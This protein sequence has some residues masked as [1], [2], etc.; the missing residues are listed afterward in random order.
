MKI[1]GNLEG[2]K[3]LIDGFISKVETDT[4]LTGLE[5][6]ANELDS[7]IVQLKVMKSKVEDIGDDL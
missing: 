5:E 7:V 3:S 4:D 1:I 2:I 6:A